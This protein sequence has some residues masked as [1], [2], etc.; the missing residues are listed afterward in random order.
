[1]YLQLVIQLKLTNQL[2]TSSG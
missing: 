2:I 1:L